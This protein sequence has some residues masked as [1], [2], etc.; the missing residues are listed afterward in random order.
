MLTHHF[1]ATEP[2]FRERAD[3]LVWARVASV[4]SNGRPPALVDDAH[5]GGLGGV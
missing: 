2:A 1:A 5:G 4:D 3:R